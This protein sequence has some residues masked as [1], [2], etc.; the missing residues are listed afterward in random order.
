MPRFLTGGCIGENEG[1]GRGRLGGKK[2]V[3][4]EKKQMRDVADEVE[5]VGTYSTLM[6][7]LLV[8]RILAGIT[9]YITQNKA[10]L[11]EAESETR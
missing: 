3:G 2:R 4:E 9:L 5:K 1:E 7:H 10:H 8:L 6:V 11:E